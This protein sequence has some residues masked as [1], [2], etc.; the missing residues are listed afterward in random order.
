M[1]IPIADLVPDDGVWHTI[2]IFIDH[3][4]DGVSVMVDG[5]DA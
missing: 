2:N 1:D 4:S 3:N 5:E